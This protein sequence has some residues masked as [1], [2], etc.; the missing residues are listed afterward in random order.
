MFFK[1]SSI[2]SLK[3]KA[4]ALYYVIFISFILSLCITS[5]LIWRYLNIRSIKTE[6]DYYQKKDDL[7][8]ALVLYLTYPE[9]YQ[10]TDSTE[11]DVF[12]DSSSIVNI[13]RKSWGVLDVLK[14]STSYRDTVLSECVIAGNDLCNTDSIALWVP[15]KS[16]ILYASGTTSITGNVRLSDK[17]IQKASIEGNVFKGEKIFSGRQM[18]S[19]PD[20]FQIA[21]YIKQKIESSMNLDSLKEISNRED[22]PMPDNYN[23]PPYYYYFDDDIQISGFSAHGKIGI[24]AKKSV[25][26]RKDNKLDGVLVV[27]DKINVEDGFSGKVQL[28]ARD[29]LIIGA[30]TNFKYPSFIVLYNQNVNPVYMEISDSTKINGDILVYQE[31]KSTKEPFLKIGKGALVRGQ[32]YVKGTINLIGRING[33]LY[34]NEFYLKTRKAFYIN[35]L[36]DN[37]IDFDSLPAYYTGLDLIGG[38]DDQII[39]F[40][41]I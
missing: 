5:L 26:I 13:Q 22:E 21:G 7:K 1:S 35:H 27:A 20:L 14:A 37:Q 17:G 33:S 31:E 6:I 16:Q 8:S 34:C 3:V 10:K 38:Y 25:Y 11:I 12:E 32:V 24:L 18:K 15:D 2:L 4:G 29:T 19:E 30:N 41:N 36:L 23:A 39:D 28:F 40:E 9:K